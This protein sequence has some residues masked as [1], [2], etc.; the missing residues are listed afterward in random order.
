MFLNFF[1][2]FFFPSLSLCKAWPMSGGSFHVIFSF[3]RLAVNGLLQLSLYFS[4]LC[5]EP[6]GVCQAGSV[7]RFCTACAYNRQ[8]VTG[9]D[10]TWQCVCVSLWLLSATRQREVTLVL[11]LAIVS[12]LCRACGLQGLFRGRVRLGETH[13]LCKNSHWC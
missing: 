2:V 11:C 1:G 6:R 4:A 5:P 9:T 3:L 12:E 10:K 8:W 13:P 7:M